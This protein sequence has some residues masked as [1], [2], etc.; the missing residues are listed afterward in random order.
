MITVRIPK[1]LHDYL[2]AE[3]QDKGTSMNR[4]CIAKLLQVVEPVEE[5]GSG[6]K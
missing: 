3:A 2:R 1:S 4:L 5:Q 6:A